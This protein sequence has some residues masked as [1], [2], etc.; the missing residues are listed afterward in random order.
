MT[1][2]EA[3]RHFSELLAR[4]AAGETILVTSHGKAVAEIRPAE[5]N[6]KTARWKVARDRLLLHLRTQTPRMGEPWTREELYERDPVTGKR[7]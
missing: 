7:L 6:S 5:E 2:T 4:V 3:N 1:A